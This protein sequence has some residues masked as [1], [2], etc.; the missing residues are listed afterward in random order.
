MVNQTPEDVPDLE[1]Y[2]MILE[3]ARG[4]KT[5]YAQ[6]EIEKR[7]YVI[8]V[9]PRNLDQG[10]RDKMLSRCVSREKLYFRVRN[11]MPKRIIV[12]AIQHSPDIFDRSFPP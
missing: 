10:M 12:T 7:K 9:S 3:P 5:E 8:T 6:I 2:S 11:Q 4:R 1:V